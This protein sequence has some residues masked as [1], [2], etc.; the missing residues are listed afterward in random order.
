MR[1]KPPTAVRQTYQAS[2]IGFFV[3]RLIDMVQQRGVRSPP[4][5]HGKGLRDDEE[6]LPLPYRGS[7]AIGDRQEPAETAYTKGEDRQ[8]EIAGEGIRDWLIRH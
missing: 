5:F 2:L 4:K 1:K 3:F 8:S 6:L 7:G